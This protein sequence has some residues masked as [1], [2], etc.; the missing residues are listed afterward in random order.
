MSYFLF[1]SRDSHSSSQC[2]LSTARV[3]CKIP[4]VEIASRRDLLAMR[5]GAPARQCLLS[6]AVNCRVDLRGVNEVMASPTTRDHRV[7]GK[8]GGGLTAS[9]NRAVLSNFI[10][11]FDTDQ[12]G[13]RRSVTGVQ[14]RSPGT[15]FY[16]QQKKNSVFFFFYSSISN[17]GG[18]P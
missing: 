4:R 10:G 5:T 11:K 16:A 1:H 18:T 8:T 12:S 6:A 7:G 13:Q 17:G 3:F 15:P 9:R 2:G 14:G